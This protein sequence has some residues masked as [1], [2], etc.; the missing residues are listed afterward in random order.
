MLG[1]A[2]GTVTRR[3]RRSCIQVCSGKVLCA[4]VANRCHW[5]CATGERG[6]AVLGEAVGELWTRE[7]GG[8]RMGARWSWL[9]ASGPVLEP[10]AIVDIRALTYRTASLSTPGPS[11]RAD[12]HQCPPHGCAVTKTTAAR[13]L[14]VRVNLSVRI[15]SLGITCKLRDAV[16][17]L[18]VCNQSKEMRE[19]WPSRPLPS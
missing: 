11:S 12:C 5:C 13:M 9:K 8:E 17:K 14:K 18:R 16:G 7:E 1:F 10:A 6:R 3:H 19:Y 4:V 2:L 15:H